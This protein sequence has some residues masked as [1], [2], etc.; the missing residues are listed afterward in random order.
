MQVQSTISTYSLA[1]RGL[2]KLVRNLS[3]LK[4][5]SGPAE[6]VFQKIWANNYWGDAESRSGGGS[7]LEQ[8]AMLRPALSRLLH[9]LKVQSMLDLPCGD[10]H[11]MQ[12]TLFPDGMKYVGGDI[13]APL[14]EANEAK[15]GG[16][17]RRFA[18]MNLME[19]PLPKVELVFCRDCLVHLSYEQIG[20]AITN[21]KR[22]GS[23][24]LLTTH[25]NGGRKN[26]DIR[27]GQWRPL[28]LS[29]APFHF[30]EPIRWIDEG[31]TENSGKF[32]DKTM[33][34]WR[35]AELPNLAL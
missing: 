27:T 22:S 20:K 28:S 15:Y 3:S 8:T 26:H 13:V 32:R 14:A 2:S 24:Y 34:L 35:I 17:T 9:E 33:A 7:N 16:A 23:T 11:W 18:Q 19:D 31:C 21:V 6:E 29:A 30:P 12:E 1:L 5:V 25:F 10:F 4:P